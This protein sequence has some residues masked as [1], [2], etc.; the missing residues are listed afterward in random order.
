MGDNKTN[1]IGPFS[2]GDLEKPNPASRIDT[3]ADRSLGDPQLKIEGTKSDATKNM[4]TSS[5]FH[6]VLFLFATGETE[7]RGASGGGGRGCGI[8]RVLSC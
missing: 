8:R 2:G 6:L 3:L 7:V 1:Y 5:F 4:R